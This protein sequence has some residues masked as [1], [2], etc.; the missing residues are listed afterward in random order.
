MAQQLAHHT[1]NGCNLRPG[2]LLASGTISGPTPDSYGSLLELGWRG[3]KPV[4]LPNGESLDEGRTAVEELLDVI[5]DP[6]H[7]NDYEQYVTASAG[8]SISRRV[9]L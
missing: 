7:I 1:I 4:L 8:V 3:T 6:Y 9:V 5:D 2:D